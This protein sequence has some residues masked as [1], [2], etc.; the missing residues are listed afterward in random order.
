MTYKA[1]TLNSTPA[2]D[3]VD[4]MSVDMVANGWVLVENDYVEGSYTWEVLRSPANLNSVGNEFFVAIGYATTGQTTMAWTGFK[5][6]NT[7]TK[8]ATRFLPNT[9]N[10][11]PDSLGYNP[12]GASALPTTGT[13]MFFR[14]ITLS[15]S[16]SYYYSVNIDRIIVTANAVGVLN[17]RFFWYMGLYDSIIPLA[18][19]P[20]PFTLTG[21]WY[22]STTGGPSSGSTGAMLT[23]PGQTVASGVNFVGGALDFATLDTNSHFWV[24]DWGPASGT[25]LRYTNQNLISRVTVNGRMSS[26][27]QRRQSLR[28]FL[29]D[30]YGVAGG[31]YQPGDIAEWVW[32]GVTYTAVIMPVATQTSS[33]Y[34]KPML[35]RV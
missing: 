22:N 12:Q 4:R 31:V 5:E 28:G 24:P 19:D 10:L 32:G 3:L 30:C 1:G 34:Y 21:S 8:R 14:T 9:D 11:V 20:M 18:V 16:D 33:L 17:L 29:K 2:K 13:Q 26:S 6:W 7:S 25:P 23:E 15:T 35:G 27:S